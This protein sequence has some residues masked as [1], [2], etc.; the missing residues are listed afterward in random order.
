MRQYNIIY[1]HILYAELLPSAGKPAE[2]GA[3]WAKRLLWMAWVAVWAV[4]FIRRTRG[5]GGRGVGGLQTHDKDSKKAYLRKSGP[6]PPPLP[7]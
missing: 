7:P 6:Y 3:V 4:E 5:V 1:L 2:P